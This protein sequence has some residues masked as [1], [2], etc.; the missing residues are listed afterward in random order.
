MNEISLGSATHNRITG[1]TTPAQ[2]FADIQ[3]GKWSKHIA[4]LRSATGDTRTKLK[5]KLPAFL[6][7]GTFSHRA[8]NGLIKHSGLICADID[9]VAER[10]TELHATARADQ[11]AVGAFISPTGTGLKVVFRADDFAAVRAHVASHY[12]AQVDEA[13]KDVA[14]LCF[15][16]HDPEAFYNTEAVPLELPPEGANDCLSSQN[17]NTHTIRLHSAPYILH[18]A[19][20]H[21]NAASVVANI[22]TKRE[23]TASLLSKYSKNPGIAKIYGDLIEG[24]HHV[25]AGERNS[26]ICK[27]VPFLYRAVDPQIAL[28]FVGCYYDCNRALFSDP[29]EQHM[30]EAT[31]ML[32]S[33]TQTYVK[34]LTAEER[35]V[36]EALPQDE[37]SA[38]RICRDLA[39]LPEPQREP[40]TFFLSFDHLGDRLGIFSMQAQRIMRQ[41]AGYGL[42]DQLEKGTRRTKGVRGNAGKY[43]WMLQPPSPSPVAPLS[44]H[45]NN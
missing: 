22:R 8:N 40:L 18:S 17:K 32:E 42:I 29:R 11:H 15:V 6:W 26:F 34:T 24:R 44:S 3:T 4:A 31:A 39:M 10:I 45:E 5:K 16:S 14:R 9:K 2:A 21:N 33:V 35:S 20:L 43:R 7:S 27:A 25:Q 38:F 41:L 13:A 23:A 28:D 19:P 1:S 36:Y 30:K 12:K 37:Q